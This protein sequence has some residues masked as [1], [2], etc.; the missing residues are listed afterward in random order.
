MTTKHRTTNW[1]AAII[2]AAALLAL[3]ACGR[4]TTQPTTVP[5]TTTAPALTSAEQKELCI[6][7]ALWLLNDEADSI[8]D[9]YFESDVDRVLPLKYDKEGTQRAPDEALCHIKMEGERYSWEVCVDNTWS[10][11][12]PSHRD[13]SCLLNLRAIE[14][15][16]ETSSQSVDEYD[17]SRT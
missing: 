1:L 2:L 5:P 14:D 6:E 9:W 4:A 15:D 7:G 12:V 17:A 11:L 8:L 16:D 10:V 13:L 3:T